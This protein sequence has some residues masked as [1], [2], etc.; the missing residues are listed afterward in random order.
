MPFSF[1]GQG[2]NQ[3]QSWTN[4][5]VSG[6]GV[7]NQSCFGQEGNMSYSYIIS[8][9]KFYPYANTWNPYQGPFDLFNTSLGGNLTS[10]GGFSARVGQTP[11]FGGSQGAPY[12]LV[13]STN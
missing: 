4:P 3:F 12:G 11:N 1:L 9:Q 7:E 2:Y 5:V 13:G 10:Y 8:F 6:L